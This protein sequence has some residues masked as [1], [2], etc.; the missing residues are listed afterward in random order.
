MRQAFDE[1][2]GYEKDCRHKIAELEV[3]RALFL[4]RPSVML[5]LVP[6]MVGT[7]KWRV[8]HGAE[9]FGTSPGAAMAAFDKEWKGES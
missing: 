1:C 3:T 6:I 2:S 4:A 5:G 9:G 8:W 7:N